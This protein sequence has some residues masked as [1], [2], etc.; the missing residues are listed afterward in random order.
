MILKSIKLTN[1]F[2]YYGEHTIDLSPK[3]REHNIILFIGN[4][5]HGKTSLLNALKIVFHGIT[6]ELCH[7]SQTGINEYVTGNTSKGGHWEGLLNR[8]SKQEDNNY[9]AIEIK[10]FEE[11]GGEFTLN[12]SWQ[13]RNNNVREDLSMKRSLGET[14]YSKEE[15]Q[16]IIN[17]RIPSEFSQF[18]FF[19][20]EK[21]Q[22]IATSS[23]EELQSSME[24]LLKIKLFENLRKHM[25]VIAED[26][27]KSAQEKGNKIIIEDLEVEITSSK[28]QINKLQSEITELEDDVEGLEEESGEVK[29]KLDMQQKLDP[30]LNKE[31]LMEKKHELERE[32]EDDKERFIENLAFKLPVILN[33]HL[34]K[35]VLRRLEN[36]RMIAIKANYFNAHLNHFLV[37]T[38]LTELNMILSQLMKMRLKIKSY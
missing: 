12:R 9:A 19:D 8:L 15:I 37:L 26:Y 2:S 31:A 4:N 5:G 30:R 20:G 1:I 25:R 17:E 7:E 22:K 6:K 13:L 10:W 36:E 24:G 38:T 32:L 3:D 33:F 28:A 14:N 21:V 18:F 35:R 16:D 27:R 23:T 34:K 29:R 11:E